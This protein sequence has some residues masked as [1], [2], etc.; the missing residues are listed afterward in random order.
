LYWGC[1]PSSIASKGPFQPCRWRVTTS[2]QKSSSREQRMTLASILCRGELDLKGQLNSL[3]QT[4]KWVV[5]KETVSV[6]HVSDSAMQ[7]S[8]SNI[9]KFNSK[10]L[11]FNFRARELNFCKTVL[12]NTSKALSIHPWDVDFLLWKVNNRM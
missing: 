3:L 1:H 4:R 7:K 12:N 8:N 5:Y 9:L 11:L 2:V 6:R 10:K